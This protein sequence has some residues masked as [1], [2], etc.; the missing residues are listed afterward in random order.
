MENFQNEWQC[1]AVITDYEE[2]KIDGLNI[3]NYKWINTDIKVIV[4]DPSYGRSYTTNIKNIEIPN[5]KIEFL[6]FEF[7]AN[8]WGIYIK[9]NYTITKAK[10]SFWDRLF[11]KLS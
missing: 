5:K 6:A 11:D 10:K 3:W 4:K 7:S 2:L 1:V 9:D 8:N